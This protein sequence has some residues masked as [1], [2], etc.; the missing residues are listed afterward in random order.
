V[1]DEEL[2]VQLIEHVIRAQYDVALKSFT[3]SQTAW[4]ELE[5]TSPDMLIVGGVMPHPCGEEIVRRSMARNATYPILLVSGCLSAEY[6]LGWFPGAPNISFLRK[7]FTAEQLY[8]EIERHF[9]T[10]P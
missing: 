1:D 8:A 2:F 7:P 4:E 6:V 5:R 9:V 10:N 3:S